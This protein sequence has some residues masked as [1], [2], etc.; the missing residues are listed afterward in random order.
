[1]DTLPIA[2]TLVAPA[3]EFPFL[4]F[5][6]L[7]RLS[8]EIVVTEKLDGTNS[9][10]YI[11]KLEDNEVM[12][13]H[14]PI[15]AVYGDLLIYAGSRNRWLTTEED[16][17]GFAKWVH[18]NHED[19]IRLGPGQHFGEWWGLGIQRNY[20]LQEKRFSL[21]N[22]GRWYRPI[23]DEAPEGKRCIPPS[24][25]HVVPELY[26]GDFDT[27]VIRS[28]LEVLA[29]NGSVAAPGF[30]NPEGVVIFHAASNQLFKKTVLKDESPKSLAE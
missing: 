2:A 7:P 18:R 9:Q 5:P 24:C 23:A 1:M 21:F 20:G 17:Y 10:I 27:T 8:R 6:K 12:P 29:T 3:P 22:T 25:C 16:N 4:P 15:I 14:T 13:T 28:R 26:R 11:K 30:M 19:L